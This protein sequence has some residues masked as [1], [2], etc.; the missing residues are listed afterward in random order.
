MLPSE[1][2]D[3]PLSVA[4]TALLNDIRTAESDGEIIA[5]LNVL[6]QH[7]RQYV[8][9]GVLPGV[10]RNITGQFFD[11]TLH[12]LVTLAF[13]QIGPPSVPFCFLSLGSNARHEM[14][15]FSD[16]DTALIFEDTDDEGV[17]NYFLRLGQ[18][19]C[20][21]LNKAGYPYCSGGIMAANPKW[22][23]P[24]SE[25]KKQIA[26]WVHFVSNESM[27]G[28][29]VFVDN[30]CVYGDEELARV[31]QEFV[32]ETVSRTPSFLSL[33]ANDALHYKV[34]LDIMG[35]IRPDKKGGAPAIPIKECL[36]P[37]E[38]FSRVYVLKN[39]I[40][41]TSTLGRLHRLLE[42]GVVEESTC[43]D[44]T[45][46]FNYLWQLRF[47]NQLVLHDDL[48]VVDDRLELSCLAEV[49][50]RNLKN[51]LA[52]IPDLQS[53]LNYDFLGGQGG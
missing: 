24:F 3:D 53:K 4:D 22:N 15:L 33:I 48:K 12:R 23:M 7:I 11:A 50:R 31:F 45:Y 6:P 13:E 9:Q 25:W 43:E 51:V 40:T 14:T 42:L 29:H 26:Q 44:A 37:L 47:Y 52:L 16:Q 27:V 21:A 19:V 10:L 41:E 28:L 8:E 20:T 38:I 1:A 5:A 32:L 17:K 2:A 30:A 46:V 39:S 49:E 18:H 36:K 35:R 34:P